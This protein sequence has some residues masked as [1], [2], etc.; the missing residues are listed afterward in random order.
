M[1]GVGYEPVLMALSSRDFLRLVIS[2]ILV[3]SRALSEYHPRLIKAMVPRITRI[4]ITTI[5]STSVKAEGILLDKDLLL[6]AIIFFVLIYE[7]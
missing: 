7:I 4:V 6:S 3:A 5:S 1:V 2:E